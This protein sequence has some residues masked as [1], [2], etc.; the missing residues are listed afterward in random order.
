M[1]NYIINCYYSFCETLSN[2]FD[3]LYGVNKNR[4]EQENQ[5]YCKMID[6]G[7]VIKKVEE[8]T[9]KFEPTARTA[10]VGPPTTPSLRIQRGGGQ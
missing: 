9:V 1:F 3:Y 2:R 8:P 6:G 5:H 7:F 10:V 4:L